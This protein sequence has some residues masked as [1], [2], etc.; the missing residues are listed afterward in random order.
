[1]YVV[2]KKRTPAR[3]CI[4]SISRG[5]RRQN[6]NVT[7]TILLPSAVARTHHGDT[8]RNHGLTPLNLRV[9]MYICTIRVHRSGRRG[10]VM[11]RRPWQSCTR[12]FFSSS[13]V[14]ARNETAIGI[15]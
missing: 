9:H 11:R 1:M 15:R 10:K 13:I 5:R 12:V 6:T 8:N 14:L 3:T 4:A 2:R 7:I